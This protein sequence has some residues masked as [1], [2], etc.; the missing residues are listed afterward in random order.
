MPKELRADLHERFADWLRGAAAAFPVVDEL[1]GYHLERA[2]AAAARARRDRGAT[3]QL[4]AR[5]SA[6]LG[7]AGRRAAQRDDPSAASALL[8]RAIALV[9]SDDAARGALLPALGASLFEAGRMAEAIARAR[10]GDRRA[11]PGR[12]WR[13]ARAIE[14]EFV[15]LEIEPSV[16]TEHARR[17][18][19]EVAAGARARGRRRRA[20][21]GV[22][23][24]A[25]RRLGRRARRAGR[26]G[27][28]RGRGLRAASAATSASCSRSS[29]WRATAAVFGPTPVDEAIRRCEEFRELVERE[30]GRGRVDGQP[31]RVAARDAA[32]DFELA[33]R[34]LQ[35]GQRDH[36][37]SSAACAR[38]CRTSR[39]WSGCSRA[40]PAL[41]ERPLRAGV[42]TLASMSDGGLLATTT[43]MLAAGGLRAGAPRGGRRSCAGWRPA[44]ARP[45]TS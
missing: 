26:R 38:A 14:R 44:P 9:E 12:G 3:A 7:A 17:V 10:R 36:S 16:G 42:E 43:A 33:E 32:V 27:L 39:R 34:L 41:A 45:T 28:E 1:L 13:R 5:A 24:C 19:D 11:H 8:E 29:A 35:R 2:V 21:P 6:H 31:A 20:V 22:V 40:E 15:R 25:P 23:R 4:A 30:P 18:V 37:T